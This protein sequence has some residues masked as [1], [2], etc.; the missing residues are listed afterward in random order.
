MGTEYRRH[1]IEPRAELE[2]AKTF[3]LE[4]YVKPLEY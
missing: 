1:F 3:A 4:A 2:L